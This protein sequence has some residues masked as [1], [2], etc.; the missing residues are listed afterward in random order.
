MHAMQALH[1]ASEAGRLE[2]AKLLLFADGQG[3]PFDHRWGNSFLSLASR[4]GKME[5]MRLLRQPNDG[6]ACCS[7]SER[8]LRAPSPMSVRLFWPRLLIGLLLPAWAG[9]R[10]HF[11]RHV[12]SR[13]A[14]N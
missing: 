1:Y 4:N 8:W 5:M 9:F 13:S 12:I 6:R 10:L 11:A 7:M 14:C 2:V 3:G